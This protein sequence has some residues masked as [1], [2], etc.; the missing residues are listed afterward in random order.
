MCGL[1][2]HRQRNGK[3]AAKKVR[4]IYHNQD[5]RGQQGF[6]FIEITGDSVGELKRF[7]YE[8]ETLHALYP[9][10]ATEI[11]FHHRI[12][13]STPNIPESNHPIPVQ[14]KSLKYD[15]YVIHNGVVSNTKVLREKYEKMGFTFT[16]TVRKLWA[17]STMKTYGTTDE[18]KTNDSEF[19][20]IDLALAIEQ[21]KEA[22]DSEGSIAFIAL[23]MEKG[24]KKAVKL[25]YGHNYRSPLLLEITD[26]LMTLS[27][28]GRGDNVPEHRLHSID[29]A[30]G[31]IED[32]RDLEI[33]NLY[34]GRKTTPTV[35]HTTPASNTGFKSKIWDATTGK[36]KENDPF[37][38]YDQEY[39]EKKYG[40]NLAGFDTQ[41]SLPAKK[42]E[43]ADNEENYGFFT[44][45]TPIQGYP[46][47]V[48]LKLSGG[49]CV[50][51]Y[52]DEIEMDYITLCESESYWEDF[53]QYN[54]KT[55]EEVFEAQELLKVIRSDL[56]VFNE[57]M[58]KYYPEAFTD[59]KRSTAIPLI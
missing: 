10:E 36:F 45:H 12:P 18:E 38:D 23:Q 52:M 48:Y 46:D 49:T 2:W 26:F 37:D 34:H 19:L 3:S 32:I 13:T 7:Q 35:T 21:E 11:L 57:D 31:L 55:T 8:K 29:Y 16:T 33:G 43:D 42:E 5:Q 4:K 22:L 1:I 53:C 40:A 51:Y 17:T 54:D 25:F 28:A 14:H 9:T 20:A 6:G 27:S 59:L 39:W 58:P 15:Y 41:R 47:G 44:L 24:S 30:T 56:K 50:Y